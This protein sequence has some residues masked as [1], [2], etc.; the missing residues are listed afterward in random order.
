MMF[1]NRNLNLELPPSPP[2]YQNLSLEL[3][4]C[5][6]IDDQSP[7]FM[8]ALQSVR[9][10]GSVDRASDSGSEGRGFKSLHAHVKR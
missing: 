6:Q 8:L 7:S 10:C 9:A 2:Y 5:V 1:T 3:L 4:V